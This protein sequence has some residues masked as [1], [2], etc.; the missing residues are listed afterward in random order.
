MS[1]E[2]DSPTAVGCDDLNNIEGNSDEPR[3][4]WERTPCYSCGRLKDMLRVEENNRLCDICDKGPI[5][6]ECYKGEWLEFCICERCEKKNTPLPEIAKLKIS[7]EYKPRFY[8]P[9]IQPLCDFCN[10][11]HATARCNDC[12]QDQCLVCIGVCEHCDSLICSSCCEWGDDECAT[13]G[14]PDFDDSEGERGKEFTFWKDAR[15]S[16]V[17]KYHI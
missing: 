10:K 13:C 4:I 15:F 14:N 16:S 17:I 5:C 7:K 12:G 9:N 11:Q 2:D 1:L 8:K 3:G 6:Y